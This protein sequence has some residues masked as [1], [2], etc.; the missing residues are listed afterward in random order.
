M[1]SYP[2]LFSGPMVR[3]LLDGTKTQTR[4]ILKTKNGGVQWNPY[5]LPGMRQ[6]LRNC[7]YGQ[8]G[9]QLWVRE[10]CRAEELPEG[11]CGVRYLANDGFVALRP[12]EGA[13]GRWIDM[14][15][16]GKRPSPAARIKTV[17]AIHMPRWAS[18]ITLE[19]T[20]VHVERLQDITESDC[21]AEGCTKNHNGYY[22]A[23]PHAISGR[24]QMATAK[25]AYRDLWES[26]NGP[27]SWDLNPW[28]WVI[29]F[30]RATP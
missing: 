3:A 17:P 4:R 19:I 30:K 26:I 24:K 12:T 11:L 28:V 21:I 16:Y 8:I 1:K 14:R 18:R 13:V 15:D 2:I 27:G 23:G 25:S 6:I 22:W 5:D 10:A 20:K 9:D 29:E 7:P